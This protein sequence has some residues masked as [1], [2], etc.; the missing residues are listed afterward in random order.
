MVRT[1]SLHDACH[2]L[3]SDYPQAVTTLDS[4]GTVRAMVI[5]VQDGDH[6][7]FFALTQEHGEDESSYSLWAWPAGDIIVISAEGATAEPD[8][9]AEVVTRGIP[10]PRDGSL[11]GW[12]SG[13][14]VTALIVVYSEYTQEHPVPGW[15]V[16]PL[17]GVPEDQ[18]PPF[19]GQ[20]LSGHWSWEQYRA[21]LFIALDGLIA[22]T[23]DTVFW[24]DT[25]A[26]LGSN[27]CAVTADIKTP[28]GD[29]LRRGRYVYY[30][31]LR[32][33]KQVP[34]LETLLAREGKIDLAPRF[35]G[36]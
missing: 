18:W 6:S 2:E 1:G 28:E 24:V 17:A 15:A 27:I 20:P 36:R 21:G 33:G 16:M 4:D 22:Q 23:P 12:A 13:G 29:T 31:V 7:G 5:L 34:S 3:F 11:F 10:I 19:A 30:E 32:A 8:V 25:K 9:V 26:T 14:A 35:S